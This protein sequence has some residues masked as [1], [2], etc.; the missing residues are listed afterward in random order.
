MFG[1]AA[2][3]LGISQPGSQTPPGMNGVT[4]L[5]SWGGWAV[6]I[7]CLAGVLIVAATMALQHRRGEG[8]GQAV[9]HLGWVL[10][11]CILGSGAGPLV[12]ALGV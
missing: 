12:T 9:G 8:G 5:L 7:A 3:V 1:T 4:T 2:V 11:A 10:A 6:S